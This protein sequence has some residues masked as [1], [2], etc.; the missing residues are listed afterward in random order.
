MPQVV[1]FIDVSKGYA[2]ID[3]SAFTENLSYTT[4]AD[5]PETGAPILAFAG[6]NFL[7]TAYGVRSFFGTNSTL[8]I[9]PLPTRCNKVLLYQFANL[10]NV[11]IALC[12]DGI[13]IT[14]PNASGASWEGKVPYG[15]I[16]QDW[17]G[18]K[19]MIQPAEGT[20][21]LEN[22]TD[23]RWWSYA[24]LYNTLY[25]YRAGDPQVVSIGPL[26]IVAGVV[27]LNYLTPTFLNMAG[28]MGIFKAN[29]RLGF[30]DSANSISWSS[31]FDP[32]D[33]TPS[34]ETLAGNAI[35]KDITGTVIVVI[36][37]GTGFII[38]S[39]KGI[40]GVRFTTTGPMPWDANNISD[41][42]GIAYPF[43]VTSGATD[44]E[45]FAYTSAGIQRV[46]KYTAIAQT[47]Q[48]ENVIPDV[49]D[50]LKESRE[51]VYLDFINGRFL[52][53]SLL[54]DKYIVG[55]L[56]YD[57]NIV[58]P[59]SIR[60]L[61]NDGPWDGI[62][63]LPIYVDSRGYTTEV[64]IPGDI[65]PPDYSTAVTDPS[66][67]YHTPI[68]DHLSNQVNGIANPD[69]SGWVGLNGEKI[70]MGIY[71]KWAGTGRAMYND[72]NM[73]VISPYTTD[74]YSNH[75]RNTPVD[76]SKTFRSDI[77]DLKDVNMG[78]LGAFNL[79]NTSVSMEGGW[80]YPG[81]NRID[82]SVLG[83]LDVHAM[84]M[85]ITQ[86][87]EWD[88]FIVVKDANFAYLASLS[89]AG[90]TTELSPVYYGSTA[91]NTA[92]ENIILSKMAS[93]P[94]AT[95]TATSVTYVSLEKDVL[96]PSSE[97]TTK[98]L[99]GAG[100]SSAT[101][102]LKRVWTGGTRIKI[103]KVF[104]YTVGSRPLSAIP[105]GQFRVSLT[106]PIKVAGLSGG[107]PDVSGH[108]TVGYGSTEEAA[109]AN[110]FASMVA[111]APTTHTNPDNGGGLRLEYSNPV[112]YTTGGG[113]Y[114]SYTEMRYAI[115]TG[116][117]IGTAQATPYTSNF[118]SDPSTEWYIT[119]TSTYSLSQ[120][121]LPGFTFESEMVLDQRVL[122]WGLA[123][124]NPTTPE[125]WQP[126][127]SI[128]NPKYSFGPGYMKEF[129]ATAGAYEIPGISVPGGA[130]YPTGMEFT[131]PGSTFLI[132][133]GALAPVYPTF[134]GAF[135]LDTALKKWGKMRNEYTTLFDI[136]PVNALTPY[137][138]A[139]NFGMDMGI[140]LT[141]GALKMMD[142][143][144]IDSRITYGKIGYYR[145]GVTGGQEVEAHFR[146]PFTGGIVC[147]S[148]LEGELAD[149][150]SRYSAGFNGVR[151]AI[152]YPPNVG[153]WHTITIAGNY[154]LQYLEFRGTI[155][156]RR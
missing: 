134:V 102:K 153:V 107:W 97:T 109:I 87:A 3:P 140:L 144:P 28:Q 81:P 90:G 146:T 24:V 20:A 11:L 41:I 39:T 96:N 141:T 110:A 150:D 48:I 9:A 52:F 1:K 133:D 88:N 2:V 113:W 132:Q 44:A 116:E 120:T 58:G 77:T 114:V 21:S 92:V 13:Y 26:D 100:T 61:V 40:V 98:N 29:G 94:G 156:G 115:S 16:Y 42:A 86:M 17:L 19:G 33:H 25:I 74:S 99:T 71:L 68:Q 151:V 119:E 38:Y 118:T 139:T 50:L 125:F 91:A 51:P 43:Q 143:L 60:I 124:L 10:Q 131:Y 123:T 8:D 138:P 22:Q 7:P 84:E 34:L 67:I 64:Y 4:G 80:I 93:A 6:Y 129:T 108:I 149:F 145:A 27:T 37:Q 79:D 54:S 35:F 83:N 45:H 89:N 66:P 82:M 155:A 31:L 57:Q 104:T 103:N 18:G 5:A 63:L 47:H 85:S 14:R 111:F 154:D 117:Y 137:I 106:G 56:E 78:A 59:L 126:S 46:G 95:R 69:F 76:T 36:P 73:A 105:S 75:T 147:D 15:W 136:S 65:I 148:S 72:R 127:P 101:Y 152:A 55:G 130:S 49:Y 32:M 142:S 23:A 122:S 121:P 62:E 112:P 30:W 12:E 53:I 135:V 70:T 128:I